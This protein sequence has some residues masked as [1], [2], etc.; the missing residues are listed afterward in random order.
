PERHR[1]V[2]PAPTRA[3]SA[4]PSHPDARLTLPRPTDPHPDDHGRPHE[5]SGLA[6]GRIDI[7]RNVAKGTKV[8]N[9]K[10]RGVSIY[11]G[12]HDEALRLLARKAQDR[13]SFRVHLVNSYS[14]ALLGKDPA[15]AEA[16]RTSDLNLP[17]G[18]PVAWVGSLRHRELHVRPFR[19]PDLMAR[20]LSEAR[21]W[22]AGHYFLGGSE[23]GQDRLRQRILA[24]FPG[25][26]IVG[27]DSPWSQDMQSPTMA[28]AARRAAESGA[29]F[30]WVGLGTPKQDKFMHYN[31]HLIPSPI[32][33]VGAALDFQA[34]TVRT[35]PPWAHGR[36]VEW[37]FRLASEPRRLARRYLLDSPTVLVD[38]ASAAQARAREDLNRKRR[39]S[40]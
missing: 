40:R 18:A 9:F 33:G 28:S 30:V 17:D 10:V 12:S 37:L 16:A 20:C 2:E 22:D 19:G 6:S 11:G 25:T 13:E 23:S 35:A 4:E 26:R 7:R 36:G 8:S 15:F 5:R 24:D 21:T 39:N 32:L 38:L 14:L 31:S 29:H 3:T 34:G 1:P 27:M